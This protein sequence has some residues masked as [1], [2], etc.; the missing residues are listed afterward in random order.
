MPPSA[1][2]NA[3][4]HQQFHQQLQPQ[5]LWCAAVVGA[6][7]LASIALGYG[8]AQVSRA[9]MSASVAAAPKAD[10]SVAQAAVIEVVVEVLEATPGEGA[11]TYRGRVAEKSGAVYRR[12]DRMVRF[13]VPE[14][15]P[16]VMGVPADLHVG[17]IVHVRGIANSDLIATDR[18]VILTPN[19]K[20]EDAKLQDAAPE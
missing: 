15:T 16:F 4:S 2:D 6:V 20:L 11:V 12:T 1:S 13:G 7:V 9:S 10:G 14:N 19:V 5:V 18:I 8:A 17:A 3:P